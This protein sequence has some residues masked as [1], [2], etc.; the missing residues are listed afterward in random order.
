VEGSTWAWLHDWDKEL[1]DCE[2]SS[3]EAYNPWIVGRC[4][5]GEARALG[6]TWKGHF[7]AR[8]SVCLYLAGARLISEHMRAFTLLYHRNRVYDLTI[9]LLFIHSYGESGD[10][11]C[12]W[13]SLYRVL[14]G[15][16]DHCEPKGGR[17]DGAEGKCSQLVV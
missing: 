17:W 16:T 5:G 11:E 8:I 13:Y 1:S 10:R 15:M 4:N 2:R 6:R 9:S 3:A 14:C 12:L 7:S